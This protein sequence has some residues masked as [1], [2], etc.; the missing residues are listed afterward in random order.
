MSTA[1]AT[2]FST[3]LRR[4]RRDAGLTQAELAERTG[5][6]TRAVS[7][8]ERGVSR[9]PHRETVLLLAQAL[10]LPPPER[11]TLVEAARRR[12]PDT[13]LPTAASAA[14]AATSHLPIPPTPL[15]GREHDETSV[16]RLLR[17]DE[18]RLLTL[19]GP[20]GVGKTRLS[21]QVAAHAGDAF[22]DGVVF[23]PLAAVSDARLVLATI[24]RALGVREADTLPAADV[25][26]SA[27]RGKRILLMVDNFE[28][29]LDAAP[30]LADL[31]AACPH[32]K[33][34]VTSRAALRLRAEQEFA[35][36]PLAL[37]NLVHLPPLDDLS[38]YAAVAL[39]VQRT[40][41]VKPG[42]D[43][44]AAQSPAV[45]ALC[46]RLDGLPLAIELAAAQG[47]LLTPEALLARL[48]RRLPLVSD[49]PRDL[50]QRQRTLRQAIAWSHDLLD[51]RERRLFRRLAVFLGGWTLEAAESVCG[52]GSAPEHNDGDVL[53]GLAALVD[54][55][56][57]VREERAPA[58]TRFTL[59][60][61]LREYALERLAASGEEMALRRAHLACFVALAETA[62]PAL[63][64]P[65]QVAWM[66]RLERELP[67]VR[68]ALGWAVAQ[69]AAEQGLRLACAL[70][71]FWRRRGH[72]REGLRWV[73]RLLALPSAADIPAT[74]RAKA[75]MAAGAFQ[76]W[77][78]D[79]RGLA[80][81]QEALTLARALGDDAFAADILHAQ[82]MVAWEL[83]DEPRG[84]ALLEAC[85]AL[86]RQASAPASI[87]QA[88]Y[89]LGEVAFT[90]GD[91][92]HAAQLNAESLALYRQVGDVASTGYLVLRE[93]YLAWVCGESARAAACWGE[94][95]ALAHD[96]GETRAM[97]EAVEAIAMLLSEQGDAR[98]PL[99][100]ATRFL[101]AAA[102]LRETHGE[103]LRHS[104]RP[105]VERTLAAARAALGQRAFAA[106]WTAGCA[107][108]WESIAAEIAPP[109]AT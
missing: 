67:N 39:F 73:E 30:A 57:V 40:R 55:S 104:Q 51:E 61:T 72:L 2:A 50:P 89:T 68:A 25:L 109:Q 97:A 14:P 84:V 103:P 58:E 106:A 107:A 41:A 69:G 93:G 64:G 87:A 5:I 11:A 3:L 62:E 31:L 98:E 79:M 49:G 48:E 26:V 94:A 63:R 33:L 85:L 90:R 82:G 54:K 28:Q 77:Q 102:T 38:Q 56:L 34:L 21:L 22:A 52:A 19:T 96:I 81:L 7:D 99:Q 13:A 65:E 37:P 75:L 18:V 29:V 47:K 105:G 66:R 45:A 83:G 9:W 35:V 88:L 8:M 27:L 71:F 92:A 108:P 95:L 76:L 100:R 70:Y 74:S 10:Q 15:I 46:A 1:Q 60:E 43:L 59:L 80:P 42:F 86:A 53:T 16:D 4:H 36:P 24:A 23:V 6:S 12:A 17:R 91:Y 101:G 20:P 32:L 78:A 44:T